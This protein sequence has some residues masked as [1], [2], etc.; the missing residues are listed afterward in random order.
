MD[1]FPDH[2]NGLGG[3][4]EGQVGQWGNDQNLQITAQKQLAHR[5]LFE[6]AKEEPRQLTLLSIPISSE[7]NVDLKR[8]QIFVKFLMN[9]CSCT[10]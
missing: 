10:K 6:P 9:I 3:V 7:L 8:S 5:S 4:G 2:P 1:A